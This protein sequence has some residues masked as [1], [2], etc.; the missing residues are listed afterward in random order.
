MKLVD[1][2][3]AWVA[4][5]ETSAPRSTSVVVGS[6][7]EV[8]DRFE[9]RSGSARWIGVCAG[10]ASDPTSQ[11]MMMFITFNTMVVRDR[12]DVDA[13]HREFLKIDEYRTRISR[14]TPGAE[15]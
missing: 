13:V 14:D 8:V 2:Y 3:V 9:R 6:K 1:A 7:S 15:D 10:A 4:S 5:I 12:V 11:A